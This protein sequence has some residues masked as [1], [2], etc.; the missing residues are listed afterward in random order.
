[1]KDVDSPSFN[2]FR[3]TLGVFL[4]VSFSQTQL[5]DSL[6][7]CKGEFCDLHNAVQQDLM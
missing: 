7:G 1:M 3:F 6:L 2:P 5:L 4:E